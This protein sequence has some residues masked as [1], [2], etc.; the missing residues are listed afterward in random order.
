MF[1][2]KQKLIDIL[3]AEVGYLEKKKNCP[4]PA[5]YEKLGAYVGA[6][7]WTKYW[8][9]A[10]DW[11]LPDYQGSYYCIEALFWGMVKAFGLKGAQK[12]CRQKFMINCQVTHDLFE[13]HNQVFNT[14][15]VGDIM[16]FWNGNRFYHAE[17]VIDV[18]GSRVKT[19]GA[20]T[21]A[22]SAI[23]NGGGCYA[24]KTYSITAGKNAGHKYLR[25]AYG[26]KAREGWVETAGK[27]KY[28]LT[29]GSF[30]ADQW[31][32]IKDRW[33]VFDGSG[34][35][36][37][38]WYLDSNGQWYYLNG[39][40][41]LSQGNWIKSESKWYY[42]AADGNLHKGWLQESSLWY[43]LDKNGEMAVGWKQ[44][45]E[46]WYVFAD[47]G[48]M[49]AN[50]WFLSKEDWYF[51][52]S[53]GAMK[54]SQWIQQDNG[55]WYYVD[56]EGKMAR[57]SVIKDIYRDRYYYV[58]KDGIYDPSLDSQQPDLE[59]YTLAE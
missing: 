54:T 42:S 12:L 38:G 14:P 9:D 3:L 26:T 39:D 2:D 53:T 50:T 29:D 43:Y 37:T 20:N 30:A 32:Y 46:I 28:Q 55:H 5:L 18:K 7:N 41:T 47:N 51:L 44:I 10:A 36:I 34:Y 35:M 49:Y 15:E 19:F 8:K 27:W 13:E 45:D 57:K 21:A 22:N 11:G 58:D 1:Y 48:K 33:Y 23:R 52:S 17:L 4:T 56:K 24:P 40:G 16:V 31:K 6:D 59:H 25:P